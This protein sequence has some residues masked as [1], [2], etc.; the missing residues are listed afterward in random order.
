MRIRHFS[1]SS[2]HRAIS[3]H[4]LDSAGACHSSPYHPARNIRIG[5]EFENVSQNDALILHYFINTI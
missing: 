4:L 1:V 3:V 5:I 2:P